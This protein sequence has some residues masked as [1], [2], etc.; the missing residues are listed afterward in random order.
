[1]PSDLIRVGFIGAG[2]IARSRHLPAL[3]RMAG[4]EVRAV[5]NRS[6][7]SGTAV[8]REFGI[9]LVCDH[10]RQ[11]LEQPDLDA[12][13]IGTWPYMHREL[14]I[15]SLEAGKHVFC[16]ARMAMDLSEA[17]EMLAAAQRRPDLVNMVC[18]PPHRMPFEAFVRQVLA[19]GQ[20]GTLTA[21]QVLS[22][23]G[24]N[25]DANTVTWRER[26]EL[27]GK[28]A[29]ALGILAEVLNAWLGPY[30]RLSAELAV[31]L[32]PKRDAGRSV[33]IKI[34]QVVNV[35]GQLHSG[36]PVIEQHTGLAA[37][38]GT[39]GQWITIWGLAGALRHRFLSD[40][41][42]IA[43]AG[44][45][46][47][48]MDV[49][50]ELRRPWRVEDDFIAAVRAARRGEKWSVSPDFAEATQYMRKVE[51]VHLSAATGKAVVLA[52]LP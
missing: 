25:L 31:P 18:P 29:L 50:A 37:D 4:V 11:V 22:V 17:L 51:A 9:P 3:T 32:S 38:Q 10:W 5:A 19:S 49:P 42:E 36:V 13:F 35:V 47:M 12:V 39:R 24:E 52:E 48:P 20:L 15:A 34:P 16:Q 21:V 30:E 23:T 43:S 6:R 8:A 14:A 28:Q 26:V 7:A 44:G 46:L 40:A 45:M 33:E 27:S 2:G 41:I 1:M